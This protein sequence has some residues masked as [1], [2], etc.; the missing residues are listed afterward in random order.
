MTDGVTV[1]A[2]TTVDENRR[3]LVVARWRDDVWMATDL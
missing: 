1:G 3:L 2:V